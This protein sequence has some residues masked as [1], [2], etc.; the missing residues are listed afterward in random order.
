[1]SILKLGPVR[2]IGY[3]VKDIEK[4]MQEWVQ[5]GVGPWFYTENVPVENFH[6][7]GKPYDLKMSIAL[8][9]SG[10]IQIELIQQRNDVPSLYRDFLQTYGE[11]VQHISHW[12]KGFDEKSKLLIDVGYK[13]GH[14][15]NIASE[16]RFG[17]FFRNHLPG[18]IIEISE[19]SDFIE[20]YFKSVADAA[21]NWDGSDPIR[22]L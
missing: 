9:N 22:L 21:T 8:S 4:A 12:V 20:E 1:M 19:N 18:P 6:Y 17:Y 13:V 11:G 15:G 2:Q 3:V 16:C 10:N 5:L 7:M 14:S